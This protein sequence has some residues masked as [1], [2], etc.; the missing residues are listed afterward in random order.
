MAKG[1]S[2]ARLADRSTRPRTGVRP[3]DRRTSQAGASGH[4]E[5]RPLGV[6]STRTPLQ[7]CDRQRESS[8]VS[9]GQCHLRGHDDAWHG[10]LSGLSNGLYEQPGCCRRRP[11]FAHVFSSVRLRVRVLYLVGV[12][13]HA[14]CR[15]LDLPSE[16]DRLRGSVRQGTRPASGDQLQC[17]GRSPHAR[18][19][20]LVRHRHCTPPG[21]PAGR[22]ASEHQGRSTLPISDVAGAG[23]GIGLDLRHRSDGS[24]VH[25]RAP[26]SR[27]RRGG[28]NPHSAALFR[29]A[30]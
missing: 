2:L 7:P 26:F 22:D 24:D 21:L 11:Q 12:H 4:L 17:S 16:P 25:R 28:T 9:F 15:V 1:R 10:H 18:R 3:V 19:H 29:G 13:P 8:H 30:F 27:Q 5:T 14:R 20:P 6:H 23:R